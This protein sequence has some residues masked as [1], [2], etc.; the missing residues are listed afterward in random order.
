L[1][2][3]LESLAFAVSANGSVVTGLTGAAMAI[4]GEA[5]RWSTST[6]MVGLGVETVFP[7]TDQQSLGSL[8]ALQYAG[9]AHQ[10]W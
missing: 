4:D 7:P 1:P 3:G 9:Q 2:G 6:G 5:F 10:G 8:E